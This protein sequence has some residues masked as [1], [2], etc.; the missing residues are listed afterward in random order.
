[1][2]KAGVLGSTEDITVGAVVAKE[3]VGADITVGAAIGAE[4][5]VGAAIGAL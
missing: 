5:V 1:M 4:K 2:L 3:V